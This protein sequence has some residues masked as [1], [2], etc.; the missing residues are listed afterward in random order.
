MGLSKL[1]RYD[2]VRVLGKGAMGT[3]YEA[4]DPNLERRVAIK[5]IAVQ[6]LSH[7]GSVDYEAR[8][9]TEARSAA[10]LQHPNIVSV[11]DSDRHGDTAYLVMEYVEGEDLRQHLER[12]TRFTLEQT[13]HIM[14]DLLAALGYAHAQNV[15]HR[16]VKPANMLMQADGRIKLTDFGVA[17]MQDALDATRT[18]GVM[19]GTLKYMSPE[20]VK[21]QPVD[22]R[23]D[24]FA[25][26]IV[27]YQLLT[28]R[29]PFSGASEFA[30][31][32]QIVG[33]NPPAPSSIHQALP[34][35]LDAVIARALA[36]SPQ[37]RYP[38]AHAFAQALAQACG[39]MPDQSVV[40][41]PAPGRSSVGMGSGSPRNRPLGL[42]GSMSGIGEMST[43]TQELE[44]LYWKDVR[45][46]VDPVDLQ[47]FLD[48]FPD[49]IYADLARRRLRKLGV[50]FV[51]EQSN[52]KFESRHTE[53]V[54]QDSDQTRVEFSH[55]RVIRPE[56]VDSAT[57]VLTVPADLRD[58]ED[59]THE[60]D[61]VTPTLPPELEPEQDQLPQTEPPAE[62]PPPSGPAA[63]RKNAATVPPES[64]WSHKR[65][66]AL[67]LAA[68]LAAAIIWQMNS[69][70]PASAPDS[71]LPAPEVL[72]PAAPVALAASGS[73]RSAAV[74]PGAASIPV[75][76]G[77]GSPAQAT[78]QPVSTAKSTP[79]L[80]DIAPAKDKASATRAAGISELAKSAAAAAATAGSQN[81][82]ASALPQAG[83]GQTKPRPT[84]SD[85][86]AASTVTS[87]ADPEL[88]CK[89]RVLLGYQL[90]MNE[91]CARPGFAGNPVCEQ[92]RMAEQS[93]RQD[94]VNRN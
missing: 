60:A 59:D 21:G 84:A 19:V 9:R 79:V 1:G 5:T 92:R 27:L 48:R 94:Q 12:G 20:Q 15:V 64:R 34:P 24:L 52:T 51:G 90:C 13:L 14:R 35:A 83:T 6:G 4:R 37:Q 33:T 88:A 68:L 28:A 10:R 54:V 58:E 7:G 2:I 67:A 91:Q 31:I 45:D 18:K 16:D 43:V 80:A 44:L 22:A 3:V 56:P 8:F 77:S 82:Q 72:I 69:T 36:K 29:Q 73:G 89:G 70:A 74:T 93:R 17:R 57:M 62:Y 63:D 81:S 78:A 26:G 23:A 39:A 47:G 75:Q 87:G 50:E 53:T 61:T 11:Y 49:G 46:A 85:S 42:S 66:G 25:A 41:P 55:T 76:A 40:P 38:D 86:A 71:A 32:G 30:I 65:S